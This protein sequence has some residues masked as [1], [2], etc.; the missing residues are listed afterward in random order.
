MKR[1]ISTKSVWQWDADLDRFV[2]LDRDG[3]WY[4]GPMALSM[5][6][7]TIDQFSIQLFNDDGT[8][9]TDSTSKAGVGVDIVDQA[10]DENILVRF[11][12]KETAGNAASNIRPQLEIR[13][14]GG[15]YQSVTGSST[16]GRSFDSTKLTAGD[17]ATQRIGSGT[18]VTDNN[19]VDDSSGA[20][21]PT[22]FVGNDEAEY[23]YCF[24]VRSADVS[25]GHN[26]EV[27]LDPAT[28][29]AYTDTEIKITIVTTDDIAVATTVA[30]TPAFDLDAPGKLEMSTTISL[31][32]TADVDA[33]GT[34]AA[35]LDV[36]LAQAANVLGG[37]SEDIAM[38]T[39][40]SLVQA[41][42]PDA[43]GTL[44]SAMAVSL[45]Q[46]AV[47]RAPGALA[48]SPALVLSTVTALNAAGELA[49][50][51]NL[52]LALAADLDAVGQLAAGMNVAL[53]FAAELA[54]AGE[55]AA[56]MAISLA[57][58]AD[59]LSVSLDDI[60]LATSVSLSQ[61]A[62]LDAEGKLAAALAV[63]LIP[64][65]DLDAAGSLA[66]PLSIALSALTD[67]DGAGEL[68][69]AVPIALSVA[70][71]VNAP[72]EL[73]AAAALILSVSAAI[74][75]GNATRV[76]NLVAR[77]ARFQVALR[78]IIVFAE[79]NTHTVKF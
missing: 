19:G 48:A 37:A 74:T 41:A 66:A 2:L 65:F 18:F 52:S 8:D 64:G 7:P 69:A 25:G 55:L 63:S 49:A 20:T 12:V 32:Q 4:D 31:A 33:T 51:L 77:D 16:I 24:Q 76:I 34:L 78:T 42:D 15:T 11:L 44:A 38:A 60:Q 43:T 13:L 21:G 50:A 29:D 23:V 61:A 17:D 14:N 71:D 22:S 46:S 67:L 1:F 56:A 36:S 58:A 5:D 68:V 79:K 54:A 40:L 26:V 3:Y 47:L 35:A 39:I 28:I 59:L 10:L 72:G 45:A 70:A 73:A 6:T 53:I 57:V 9:E 62:D 30:L 27:R 75:D